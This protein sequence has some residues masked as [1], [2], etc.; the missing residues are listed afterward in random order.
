MNGREKTIM[1]VE[2]DLSVGYLLRDVL[3][4]KGYRCLVESDGEAVLGRSIDEMPD[5]IL[6]DIKLV[7][8]DG[9]TVCRRLKDDMSTAD[10]P[11]IFISAL[12]TEKDVME[13]K[14]AGGVYFVG[15]PFDLDFLVKKIRE[16]LVRYD[17]RKDRPALEPR[18]LFVDAAYPF[19]QMMSDGALSTLL[20]ETELD[21]HLLRDPRE[22][23]RYTRELQPDV[24]IL[25]MDGALIPTQ[26]IADALSHNK[27]T[28][29]IPVIILTSMNG[30][31]RWTLDHLSNVKEVLQKPLSKVELI[32][33]VRRIHRGGVHPLF[34]RQA[35]VHAAV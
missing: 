33:A 14:R 35:S 1:I 19:D 21:V 5:L 23:L 30:R 27:L 29:D 2:D 15:K 28:V 11:V 34:S 6:L 10:I 12:N 20:A 9:F 3:E 31:M 24:I 32:R 8:I 18:V 22:T 25:D 26:V 7:G 4:A 13:A 16:I 17:A